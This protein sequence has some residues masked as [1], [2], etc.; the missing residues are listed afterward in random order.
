MMVVNVEQSAVFKASA[1][2]VLFEMPMPERDPADPTRYGVT[3]D[4]R[5]F[6]ALTTAEGEKG[7]GAPPPITVVL[8][9][10]QAL[11]R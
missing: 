4:A 10:A 6:L 3:P 5:R 7:A 1:P 11:K 8:N 9:Y 2:R